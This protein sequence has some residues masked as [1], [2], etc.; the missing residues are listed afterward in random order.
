[1]K[2]VR[3]IKEQLIGAAREFPVV[4]VIGPRQSGK[5]TLVRDVFPDKPYRS[6]ENPDIRAFAHEDPRGFLGGLQ[7]GAVLDEIQ[8]APALL[9]YLQ[10]I[11]DED[12]IPGRFVL[13]GS[14][15][16]LLMEGIGQSL[17]G[18][19]A[20]LTLLPLSLV[21]IARQKPPCALLEIMQRGFYPRLHERPVNA[22]A[23]QR[24]YFQTYVE[25]DV[26]QLLKVHDLLTFET[27]V[28]LCAGRVGQLLNLASLAAD[29]GISSTTARDWISIL[30]ASFIL[31]RLQPWHANIS[32]RLI[33]TPKLYFHDVG[34][35]AYL[36]G[37][38]EQGQIATHPLRGNLFENMVVG[39]LLKRRFNS[40]LDNRLCFFRDRA[41]SEVDILF[42]NGPRYLPVE[43]KSGQTIHSEW[44]KP[45]ASMAKL[46]PAVLQPGLVVYGGDEIQQR[47][48]GVACGIW[49]MAR[50]LDDY[51]GES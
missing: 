1:M 36:C 25:R 48:S 29:S 49:D 5:T 17:A 38:E 12:N 39:E 7:S 18:R 6:L 27:F 23:A 13:T 26:R 14:Q 11:V 33:K 20:L 37:I 24:D 40:G 16:F 47:T 51:L 50:V 22:Y 31:F 3:D 8:R 44:F 30:E 10:G 35:A 41:G 45:L 15:H 46:N 43:I 28:R 34:L 4:T 9:S 32:K 21:E 19:T 42:P 2:Y